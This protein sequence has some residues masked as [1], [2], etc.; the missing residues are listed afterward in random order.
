MLVSETGLAA[1]LA[2]FF[3]FRSRR[4]DEVIRD[5]KADRNLT[6]DLTEPSLTPTRLQVDAKS[7][8]VS[9]PNLPPREMAELHGRRLFEEMLDVEQFEPGDCIDSG[10]M[11][12]RYEMLCADLGW[13][14]RPWNPVA[15]ALTKLLGGKTYREVNSTRKHN[16]RPRVYIVPPLDSPLRRPKAAKKP[17]ASKPKRLGS[18]AAPAANRLLRV[19]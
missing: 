13:R 11:Y 12:S 5:G 7:K 4:A 14:I 10:E 15:A 1:S 2:W 8:H 17:R 18:G 16:R 19:V 9:I 6:A 3:G